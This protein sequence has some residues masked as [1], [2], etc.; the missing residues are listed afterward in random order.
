MSCAALMRNDSILCQ[1]IVCDLECFYYFVGF[2]SRLAVDSYV[3]IVAGGGYKCGGHAGLFDDLINVGKPDAPGQEC[4][5]SH[6]IGCID[7]ASGGA[8]V[9]KSGV[10]QSEARKFRH[11]GRK[12]VSAA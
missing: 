12:N 11:V 10:S 7:G 8:S 3:V 4:R 1:S 2:G 6:F 5:Y 9:L